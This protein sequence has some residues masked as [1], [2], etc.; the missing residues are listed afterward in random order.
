MKLQHPIHLALLTVIVTI[1]GVS[2]AYAESASVTNAVGSSRLGC[3]ADNTCFTPYTIEISVGDTVTWTNPDTAAHTVV[4]G[5]D[6]TDPDLGSLFDSGLILPSNSFSHQFDEAGTFP[7]TCKVH[8]HMKGIV[9]VSDAMMEG[10]KMMTSALPETVDI[11]VVLPLTGSLSG[12]GEQMRASV[13]LAVADFNDYLENSDAGWSL[14]M[15]LEDTAT[16]PTTA[17]HVA[18]T[19]H[20]KNID[21]IIGPA[22]SSTT[23]EIKK[24]ADDNNMLIFSCC[25]TAP[26]LNIAGDSVYRMV[27][28][29]TNQGSALGTLLA[30]NGVDVVVP[31]WRG[32]TYGD[33]LKKA[34]VETFEAAGGIATDGV[35]Y[36]P[37]ARE[38]SAEVSSLSEE[39]QNMIDEHGVDNVAIMFI[40]FGEATQIIQVAS[41]Y[42]N[43]STVD[44]YGSEA[45]ATELDLSDSIVSDF[46]ADTT[47]I[48]T[49][50][51]LSPGELAQSITDRLTE[52]L[53]Y[54]PNQFSYAAYDS[55]QILGKAIKQADSTDASDIK[56]VIHSVAAEH[57]GALS[58]A[59]LNEY[60]DL[61]TANYVIST[62]E[63]G[64]WTPIQKYITEYNLITSTTQPEGE[65]EI[66]SLYPLT[67]SSSATGYATREATDLGAADFNKLLQSI[68]EEWH[69]TVVSED[70]TSLP[71][72]ALEK[73]QTLFARNIDIIIGPR[74]SGEVAQVK[75]YADINN[76]MVISCCSTAPR[77]SL[78]NDSVYRLVPD[79][80]NQ[81][82]A[83]AKL[84][85]TEGIEAIVPIIRGDAYGVGL[86]NATI[87]EF[88]ELGY[89][90][91][92]VIEFDPFTAITP[93]LLAAELN[94]N[95]QD[96]V[97]EY[98]TDKVAVLI[99]AFDES[100]QIMEAASQYDILSEVRWFGAETFTSKTDI[101]NNAITNE[102]VT[103]TS[104]TSL[105]FAATTTSETEEYIRSYFMSEH[106][107]VPTQ[108][109]R[110]AYD[111][112]WLVGLSM[113]YSGAT[114]AGTVKEVFHDVAANYE[115]AVGKTVLNEAGDLTPGDY[116]IWTVTDDGWVEIGRYSPVDK[117]VT[118]YDS[119]ADDEMSDNN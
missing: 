37:E 86:Q 64:T 56:A 6:F 109:V 67:G 89:D 62:A 61:S 95:V 70:S 75:Q 40:A 8:P 3:E 5:V 59:D 25:S 54:T 101:L 22:A 81:G 21:L 11:G 32:D 65:I 87:T 36:T 82:R 90:A 105:A 107:E 77:L 85:E 55:V 108:Y 43:L 50:L 34:T 23:T 14:N 84:F 78:P 100:V 88:M 83:L 97:D 48:A 94:D 74:P 96:M 116:S 79:D 111:I 113:L 104:F 49:D 106:G 98:G 114:D 33:G 72:I 118:Y 18:E 76:M 57:Q 35:R 31:I 4:S 19:L 91:A 102:L 47:F 103:T 45:L 117:A 93:G 9:Q 27:A 53:G 52:T 7:Y 68:G 2:L 80:A 46:I 63:D 71:T 41:Q 17:R 20:S 58:N 44:W 60:G 42:D 39:V 99:T 92:Q 38:F 110:N 10:D 15:V 30:T 12:F 69:L 115:G 66:G 13:E 1:S 119:M 73:A 24:Y 29:D 51:L 112:P 16:M 26:S 28:D